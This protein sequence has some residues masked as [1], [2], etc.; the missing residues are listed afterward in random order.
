MTYAFPAAP[1]ATDLLLEGLVDPYDI[2]V[3]NAGNLFVTDRGGH[4]ILKFPPAQ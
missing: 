4:R 3:D 2:A 1:T